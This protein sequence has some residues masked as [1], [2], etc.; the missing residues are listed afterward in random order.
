MMKKTMFSMLALSLLGAGVFA[1]GDTKTPKQVM[2]TDTKTTATETKSSKEVVTPQAL[3][4]DLTKHSTAHV[5]Q[6]GTPKSAAPV[7]AVKN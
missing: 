4:M 6:G 7:F 2:K 1:Q 3:G 5:P